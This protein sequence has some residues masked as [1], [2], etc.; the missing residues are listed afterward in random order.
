MRPCASPSMPS[1]S[2]RPPPQTPPRKATQTPTPPRSQPLPCR[3]RP[4]SALLSKTIFLTCRSFLS[5][6]SVPSSSRLSAIRSSQ[7]HTIAIARQP[8]VCGWSTVRYSRGCIEEPDLP[9]W[10]S[11]E[12]APRLRWRPSYLSSVWT[13]LGIRHIRHGEHTL[14][15]LCREQ[16]IA[17]RH[18][19]TPRGRATIT[20]GLCSRPPPRTEPQSALTPSA[21]TLHGRRAIQP[22]V[23]ARSHWDA[24]GLITED[25]QQLLATFL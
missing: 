9:E 15:P 16:C 17:T 14:C 7:A 1:C 20:G 24:H 11:C 19:C 5:T 3:H 18:C 12:S 22:I 13:S 2:R 21:W 8:S 4:A 6:R 23:T 10:D 25:H